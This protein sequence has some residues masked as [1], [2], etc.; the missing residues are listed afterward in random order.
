MSLK[1]QFKLVKNWDV[2]GIKDV[3]MCEATLN[4]NEEDELCTFIKSQSETFFGKL[5]TDKASDDM[6]IGSNSGNILM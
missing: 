1:I 6:R 5:V 3:T 2:H 4:M